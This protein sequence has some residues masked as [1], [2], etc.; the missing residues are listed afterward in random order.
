M[1]R[2]NLL[3]LAVA[4]PLALLP[5]VPG[6]DPWLPGELERFETDLYAPNHEPF[7]DTDL[8]DEDDEYVGDAAEA[9]E[10]WRK[11]LEILKPQL[12]PHL[13]EEY[14]LPAEVSSGDHKN[15]FITFTMTNATVFFSLR[16]D[17]LEEARKQVCP[18]WSLVCYAECDIYSQNGSELHITH[19]ATIGA[20]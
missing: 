2:R 13:Y 20:K 12:P 11:M 10:R 6:F 3:K 19:T 17:L 1:N 15:L 4:S 7:D 14:L 18:D 8:D 16:D 5:Q 9:E